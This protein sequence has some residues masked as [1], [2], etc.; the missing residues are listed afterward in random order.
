MQFTAPAAALL[1]V[2]LL[3]LLWLIGFPR[4]AFR[5]RRDIS[6]LLL[7]SLI[8]ALLVLALAGLQQV[9]A[10][11][12]LAVVFLVDAS[13][14]MGSDAESAQLDFLSQALANKPR[15]DE[16]SLLVFG[17]NAVPE[18]DFSALGEIDRFIA[19]TPSASGTNIAKALQT[20]LAMFPP[21]AARRIVILS[22]G[23]ATR[24]DALARA[25]RAAAAGVEVSYVPHVREPAPDVRIRSLDAPG[26]VAQEQAFDIAVSIEAD[27]DTPATLADLLRR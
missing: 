1:L 16:W 21:D 13:D 24:G 11:E 3:P 20:A 15:D 26:R 18:R 17:D 6:S 7:R 22:D 12:R 27:R 9:G 8:V 5:R 4:H 10:V 19:S 23:K 14:S 2:I 25:Q